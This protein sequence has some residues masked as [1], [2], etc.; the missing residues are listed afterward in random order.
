MCIYIYIY[1]YI[2]I[3]TYIY[4]YIYIYPV[5]QFCRRLDGAPDLVPW[6]VLASIFVLCCMWI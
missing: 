2:C 5:K 4:I 3:H 6:Y 1:I